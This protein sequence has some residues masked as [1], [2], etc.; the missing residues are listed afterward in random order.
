MCVR[1]LVEK[2]SGG[3]VGAEEPGA[4]PPSRRLVLQVVAKTHAQAIY[5]RA[6][7]E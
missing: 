4:D 7:K 1:A 3:A 5:T 2:V 6:T